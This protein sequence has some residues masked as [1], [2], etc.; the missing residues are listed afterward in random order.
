MIVTDLP[1]GAGRELSYGGSTEGGCLVVEALLAPPALDL[2]LT[3][4]QDEDAS[5][6]LLPGPILPLGTLVA[7]WPAQG[8]RI[9][10][11]RFLDPDRRGAEAYRAAPPAERL[12]WVLALLESG[13]ASEAE[14]APA[15]LDPAALGY[16]PSAPHLRCLDPQAPPASSAEAIQAL[17]QTTALLL[18]GSLPQGGRIP[19]GRVAP[20]LERLLERSLDPRPAL[21]PRPQEF[22]ACLRRVLAEEDIAWRPRERAWPALVGVAGTLAALAAIALQPAALAPREA[23]I[24]EFIDLTHR[25]QQ[26]PE[27]A[28]VGLEQVASGPVLLPEAKRAL[29]LEAVRRWRASASPRPDQTAALVARLEADGIAGRDDSLALT[30]Q[31]VCGF[32]RRWELAPRGDAESGSRGDALLRDLLARPGIDEGLRLCASAALRGRPRGGGP[33]LLPGQL[34]QI[35]A[36]GDESGLLQRSYPA[37]VYGTR[38]QPAAQPLG[39]GWIAD[40][41]AGQ[42]HAI[43]GRTP[44]A[45]QRLQRAYRAFPCYATQVSLGLSLLRADQRDQQSEGETLLRAPAQGASGAGLRLALAE[46]AVRAGRLRRAI[47]E[48]RAVV[49]QEGASPI[50]RA[51]AELTLRRVEIVAAA[52]LVSSDPERAL[53]EL[54][55]L[56]RS[57]E[58]PYAPDLLLIAAAAQARQGHTELGAARLWAWLAGRPLSEAL[59]GLPELPAAPPT[60]APEAV[61][62]LL[63]D[64]LVQRLCERLGS[65]EGSPESFSERLELLGPARAGEEPRFALI[66]AGTSALACAQGK[67]SLQA[68]LDAV[69]RAT[70]AQAEAAPLALIEF[71][72][73]LRA[74]ADPNPQQAL[75]HLSG[76]ERA[77]RG[78]PE[79]ARPRALTR[80]RDQLRSTLAR[81]AAARRKVWAAITPEDPKANAA[82]LADLPTLERALAALTAADASGKGSARLEQRLAL[83]ELRCAAALLSFARAGSKGDRAPQAFAGGLRHARAG[84]LLLE[85]LPEEPEVSEAR[86]RLHLICGLAILR[87]EPSVLESAADDLPIGQPSPQAAARIHLHQA[88]GLAGA[89]MWREELDSGFKPLGPSGREQAPLYWVARSYWEEAKSASPADRPAACK[90]ARLAYRDFEKV[91]AQ[92]E[93][94]PGAASWRR[95]AQSIPAD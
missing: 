45:I 46:G 65:G 20:P 49:A 66:G 24:G 92:G 51:R 17:A 71:E 1:L 25:L 27:L 73:R 90:A 70:A 2:H 8:A 19:P 72:L 22:A 81:F 60:R 38:A 13:A 21:R 40:L 83:V 7:E 94:P 41:L 30:L 77:L 33:A 84:L 42:H 61:R 18:L 10:S 95:E 16:S 85:P 59:A 36:C 11:A 88:G 37:I 78:Y 69:A 48:L 68:A 75:E 28:R 53:S 35:E 91:A 31:L 56:Q 43:A 82:G 63:L 58:D 47:D 6:A 4:C 55:H 34:D 86:K 5:R 39:L 26:D 80:W 93:L 29:A 9:R 3:W 14:G 44:A 79:D 32:L 76:A 87:A 74:A 54:T 67:Q 12:R 62:G 23:A 52:R 89:A 50:V 64:D 15:P 57:G